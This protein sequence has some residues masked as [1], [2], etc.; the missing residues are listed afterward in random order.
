MVR[1][2]LILSLA[3]AT[4]VVTTSGCMNAKVKPVI[5]PVV[6]NYNVQDPLM[7]IKRISIEARDELRLLAKAQQALAQKSM[8]KEQHKQKSFQAM[9]I[10]EGFD[11]LVTLKYT[12]PVEAVVKLV[13]EAAGYDFRPH[14]KRPNISM[15]VSLDLNNQPLNDALKELGMQTGDVA[16][17][18][19]YE[20]GKI[21]V[22]NYNSKQQ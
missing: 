11:K 3:V 22:L 8:T 6:K 19:V 13:A 12:A 2:K 20:E 10:P 15:F 17:V 4:V 5:E 21:L 1:K 7:A 14:G 18:E 9:H 16:M